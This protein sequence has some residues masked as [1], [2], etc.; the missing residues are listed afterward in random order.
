MHS[1]SEGPF[2]DFHLFG[3]H[4]GE[5]NLATLVNLLLINATAK[6]SRQM[7]NTGRNHFRDFSQR[8][9]GYNF[10]E[11]DT[12]KTPPGRGTVWATSQ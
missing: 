12:W 7:A 4:I 2:M 1:G 8:I 6:T 5:A 10:A 9:L 3:R 11:P